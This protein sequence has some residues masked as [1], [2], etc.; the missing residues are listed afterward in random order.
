MDVLIHH[1]AKLF[2]LH[3]GEF[4]H[5]YAPESPA[6]AASRNRVCAA[7]SWVALVNTKATQALAAGTGR[8]SDFHCHDFPR[9]GQRHR[10]RT[11]EASA[12]FWAMP[13]VQAAG[14]RYWKKMTCSAEA[15]SQGACHAPASV[16]GSG[17]CQR[18][19][20]AAC[21]T[22]RSAAGCVSQCFC[23]HTRQSAAIQSRK[24]AQSSRGE[25][26]PSVL[27]GLARLGDRALSCRRL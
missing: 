24:P 12:V 23:P 25:R 17:A 13:S 4:D 22:A 1:G 18:M 21:G 2:P 20:G 8:K 26:R 16:A 14:A 11:P 9:D 3:R 27:E 7:C 6:P 10:H 19:Q 5:A 15:I